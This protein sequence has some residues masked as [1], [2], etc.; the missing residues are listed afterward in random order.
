MPH[1]YRVLWALLVALVLRGLVP[2]GYMP[3][4]GAL[5][6]GRVT[7]TLCTAAGTVSTVIVSL[8]GEHPDTSQ[9]GHQAATGLDCPFGLLTHLV[10][11]LPLPALAMAPLRLAA[12]PAP[13][14]TSPHF[15]SP[16]T[17]CA[18][19]PPRTNPICTAI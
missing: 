16:L 15:S 14:A 11:A 8:A 3:D 12:T 13:A 17:V 5:G 2:P 1:A 4:T 19:A 6:Q 7:L 18:A 10:P 9:P